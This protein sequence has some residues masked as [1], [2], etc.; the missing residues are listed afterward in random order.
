MQAS[1]ISNYIS[2]EQSPTFHP[3][4]ERE[5]IPPTSTK[6]TTVFF[7]KFLFETM[8]TLAEDCKTWNAE[9][10]SEMHTIPSLKQLAI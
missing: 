10:V 3:H 8:N 7:W 5:F 6:F 9:K 2:P 4:K 1:L